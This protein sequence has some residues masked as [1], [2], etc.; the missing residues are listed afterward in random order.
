MVRL[1]RHATHRDEGSAASVIQLQAAGE[2]RF[3]QYLNTRSKSADR[4]VSGSG[5]GSSATR[6]NAPGRYP[7]GAAQF[8][9][10]VSGKLTAAPHRQVY[11]RENRPEARAPRRATSCSVSDSTRSRT[12]CTRSMG[13]CG[14]PMTRPPAG[15]ILYHNE[16]GRAATRHDDAVPEGLS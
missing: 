9:H 12:G 6:E 13:R 4:A 10:A 16:S 5:P 8:A 1:R 15:Y 7:R 11:E 3:S 2:L 14:Y